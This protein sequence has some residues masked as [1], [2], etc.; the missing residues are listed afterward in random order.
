VLWSGAEGW[1]KLGLEINDELLEK[2]EPKVQK[3]LQ[4]TFVNG[5]DREDIAQELRIAIL[6]A[7]SHF[8]DTKGVIFHTYLHT[9]MVNTLRTLI[10][11]AQKTKNINITYSIDGMEAGDDP[12]G[13]LPNEIAISL[14]DSTALEFVNDIELMDMV[15]RADLTNQE[16]Y[17]LELRLEGMTMEY[18]SDRLDESAYKVRNSIQKKINAFI[19]TKIKTNEKKITK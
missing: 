15:R 1:N 18:I 2:W 7:A 5:M 17:F 12:D 16:T 8:D 3:F 4:T 14:S 10:A 9:A 13:F 19:V 6:K 11:K